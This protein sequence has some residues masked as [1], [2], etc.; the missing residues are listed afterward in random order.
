MSQF[1][2]PDQWSY[3]SPVMQNR[4]HHPNG[5]AQIVQEIQIHYN[6]PKGWNTTQGYQY[7]LY[8]SQ[9]SQAYCYKVE[10]EYFR[11]LR[12]TCTSS[13]PGC[14]MGSMYWQTN[15]IW[16]GA[17]WSGVD[18]LNRYKLVGYYAKDFY[19][20]I[21]I[22]GYDNGSNYTFWAVN[23][24]TDQYKCDSTTQCVVEFRACSF[25]KSME[26]NSW[27]IS[28]PSMDYESAKEFYSLSHADFQKQTKCS[29]ISSDCG[30]QFR[31][32]DTKSNMVVT[33]NW[34]FVSSPKNTK[35][36][37][38]QLKLNGVKDN[39]D[40]TF[41]V[42]FSVGNIAAIV[43]LETNITG[44]FERNGWGLVYPGDYSVQFNAS[45]TT[46]ASKLQSTLY[47]YS[48]YEAG[49]FAS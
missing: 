2:P 27:N 37:D 5:Q 21:L 25:T 10:V 26:T 23:D 9:Y 20:K 28:L 31:L 14:T 35:A 13:T 16:P 48:L 4:Q 8:A 6:L 7:M 18:Y 45:E 38:P 29:N 39:N 36:M 17:S 41:E 32:I 49:G 40:N 1:L 15:D 12:Q 3:N 22:T 24:Y 11:S 46:T 34:M 33:E 30:L 19:Q 47:L 42:S 44:N 43:Y